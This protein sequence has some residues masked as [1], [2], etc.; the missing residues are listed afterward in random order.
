LDNETVVIATVDGRIRHI[1]MGYAVIEDEGTML[2]IETGDS[3]PRSQLGEFVERVSTDH[4][5]KDW[6]AKLELIRRNILSPEYDTRV[7]AMTKA[8]EELEAHSDE[9]NRVSIKKDKLQEGDIFRTFLKIGHQNRS[10][11]VDHIK[12]SKDGKLV[13]MKCNDEKV[14]LCEIDGISYRQIAEFDAKTTV[15]GA[16]GILRD[17]GGVV[18]CSGKNAHIYLRYGEQYKDVQMIKMP[19]VINSFKAGNNDKNLIFGCEDGSAYMY[20][21]KLGMP[22][23]ASK[24]GKLIWSWNN[25]IYVRQG[26]FKHD[27]PVA[28]VA[29][30]KDATTV[31]VAGGNSSKVYRYASGNWEIRESL[32]ILYTDRNIRGIEYSP[33]E[34]K[35]VVADSSNETVIYHERE[36]SYDAEKVFQGTE[37]WPPIVR[38]YNDGKTLLVLRK[39]RT[40]EIVEYIDGQYVVT[41][42]V[43]DA[44]GFTQARVMPD[45]SGIILCGDDGRL[46]SYAEGLVAVASDRHGYSLETG[47][48]VQLNMFPEYV[49]RLDLEVQG[50]SVSEQIGLAKYA[51]QQA[52]SNSEKAKK[53]K[54]LGGVIK[55]NDDKVET[56]DCDKSVLGQYDVIKSTVSID[57][58]GNENSAMQSDISKD[59][60]TMVVGG[61]LGKVNVYN[62]IEGKFNFAHEIA[63]DGS[64]SCLQISNDKKY[65]IIG[66]GKNVELHM[67][68][69]NTGVYSQEVAQTL[70]FDEEVHDVQMSPNGRDILVAKKRSL[71]LYRYNVH[72]RNFRRLSKKVHQNVNKRGDIRSLVFREDGKGFAMG[73]YDGH[74]RLFAYNAESGLYSLY[75][76]ICEGETRPTTVAYSPDYENIYVGHGGRL[77]VHSKSGLTDETETISGYM[78][79]PHPIAE[80]DEGGV[81]DIDVS[82]NGEFVLI[83]T[84]NDGART[85]RYDSVSETYTEMQVCPADSTT[86]IAKFLPDGTG[87]YHAGAAN[88]I[89]VYKEGLL[90]IDDNEYGYDLL[91][92]ERIRLETVSSQV[93]LVDVGTAGL[94]WEEKVQALKE[95][96]A[97]AESEREKEI[98]M[99]ALDKILQ[100]NKDKIN[101]EFVQTAQMNP[102]SVG[103]GLTMKLVQDSA[104]N[105]EYIKISQNGRIAVAYENSH[106]VV[107]YRIVNN[108]LHE[109]QRINRLRVG[110]KK[111]RKYIDISPD[112]STFV[113]GDTTAVIYKYNGSEFSLNTEIQTGC[114]VSSVKFTNDGKS[115]VVAPNE[116]GATLIYDMHD[117]GKFYEHHSVYGSADT[118]YADVTNDG[119]YLITGAA[120]GMATLYVY[121]VM[122]YKDTGMTI[123]SDN[124][125][126]ITQ[127]HFLGSQ[128]R[129]LVVT[130]D[131]ESYIYVL[132]GN[133]YKK[134][135]NVGIV[136][137]AKVSNDG[138]RFVVAHDKEAR[139]YEFDGNEYQC[140]DKITVTAPLQEVE[141]SG[142]NGVYLFKE[143]HQL[144][145]YRNTSLM[146][147]EDGSVSDLE[148]GKILHESEIPQTVNK[149]D[150]ESLNLEWYTKLAK[151]LTKYEQ[152]D[153]DAKKDQLL[154]QIKEIIEAHTGDLDEVEI[155]KEHLAPMTLARAL[156][157][158][159]TLEYGP[160]VYGM[161]I[162][163]DG[164]R[165]IIVSAD[166]MIHIYNMAEGEFQPLQ[167]LP[168]VVSGEAV[169]FSLD[170]NII[171]I[172]TE[173]GV[174]LY[175]FDG[176][177][178]V[179]DEGDM[180]PHGP[181][182]G[183]VHACMFSKDAKRL[184]VRYA[185]LLLF[186]YKLE[187]GKYMKDQEIELSEGVQK[188]DISSD[189]NMLAIG[190]TDGTVSVFTL[191]NDKYVETDHKLKQGDNADNVVILEKMGGLAVMTPEE[192]SYVYQFDGTRYRRSFNLGMI[193]SLVRNDEGSRLT[194][195]DRT[196]VRLYE[197]SQDGIKLVQEVGFKNTVDEVAFA[198]DGGIYVWTE[199][200][201]CHQYSEDKIVIINENEARNIKT[202][203]VINM[204]DIP[205]KVACVDLKYAG[206][207]WR[208]R[209]SRAI[210]DYNSAENDDDINAAR[211]VVGS[212]L[213]RYETNMPTE[214]TKTVQ[215]VD[216]QIVRGLVQQQ[217]L[218]GQDKARYACMSAD[219]K[220]MARMHTLT[221]EYASGK[222]TQ[223]LIYIDKFNEET[224][225]YQYSHTLNVNRNSVEEGYPIR[226]SSDPQ[227]R[228]LLAGNTSG[229]I[230]FERDAG[231]RYEFEFRFQFNESFGDVRAVDF[232]H[233]ASEILISNENE[234]YVYDV[235]LKQSNAKKIKRRTTL[236]DGGTARFSPDGTCVLAGKDKLKVYK[237]DQ[238]GA[239]PEEGQKVSEGNITAAAWLG[240]DRI[241]AV[242][243]AGIEAADLVIYR[244][245]EA[246]EYEEDIILEDYN[247][248]KGKSITT[249]SDGKNFIIINEHNTTEKWSE[250]AEGKFVCYGELGGAQNDEDANTAEYSADGRGIAVAYNNGETVTFVNRTMIVDNE[251]QVTDIDT[252]EKIHRKDLPDSVEIAD[253]GRKPL[254]W[255]QR[256]N[257][258]LLQLQASEDDLNGKRVARYIGGILRERENEIDT[259]MQKADA[260][261]DL[262]VGRC[263]I[264]K[265]MP[266]LGH[267]VS[268]MVW[269]NDGRRVLMQCPDNQLRLYNVIGDRFVYVQQFMYALSTEGVRFSQDG[270]KIFLAGLNFQVFEYN[271]QEQKY[272]EAQLF[273]SPTEINMIKISP[274]GSRIYIAGNDGMIYIYEFNGNEYAQKAPIQ[275]RTGKLLRSIDVSADGQRIVVTPSEEKP[276]IYEFDG[277]TYSFS[278]HVEVKENMLDAEFLSDGETIVVHNFDDFELSVV[279]YRNGTYSEFEELGKVENFTLSNDR[280]TVIGVSAEGKVVMYYF[281]GISIE[282]EYAMNAEVGNKRACMGGDRRIFVHADNNTVRQ[283]MPGNFIVVDGD[284]ARDLSTGDAF[285][286]SSLPERVEVF[287]VGE[288]KGFWM[289]DMAR[290]Q[291]AYRKAENDE[292]RHQA[293]Q[294]IHRLLRINRQDL[295]LRETQ[296]DM[297]QALDVIYSDILVDSIEE[298]GAIKDI[299]VSADKQYVACLREIRQGRAGSLGAEEYI[300][301][302]LYVYKYDKLQDKYVFLDSSVI[303]M[304]DG[305]RSSAFCVRFSKDKES[306]RLIIGGDGEAFAFRKNSDGQY[307]REQHIDRTKVQGG[308]YKSID[309]SPDGSTAIL[310]SDHG[311]AYILKYDKN[312][313]AGE[314]YQVSPP[315]SASRVTYSEDG[316]SLLLGTYEMR[317]VEMLNDGHFVDNQNSFTES[318]SIDGDQGWLANGDVIAG[319]D[320]GILRLFRKDSSG[321]YAGVQDITHG[322]SIVKIKVSCSRDQILTI[323]D[324]GVCRL[325][326]MDKS[327]RLEMLREFK[328]FGVRIATVDFM[329]DGSGFL[330]GYEDKR[331]EVF[332]NEAI[333]VDNEESSTCLR[334]GEP[335]ERAALPARVSV[336]AVEEGR[337]SEGRDDR[338]DEAR[339]IQAAKRKISGSVSEDEKNAGMNALEGVIKRNAENMETSIIET[340]QLLANDIA[341][342]MVQ[343]KPLMSYCV[344][345]TL[346]AS[347]NGKYLAVVKYVSDEKSNVLI[348]RYDD[349]KMKYEQ[350]QE[351]VGINTYILS[352]EF[353]PDEYGSRLVIGGEGAAYE[354]TLDE[355]GEYRLEAEIGVG[356]DGEPGWGDATCYKIS[357]SS[358]GKYALFGLT[359]DQAIIYQFNA[360]KKGAER[361]E[362]I[363]S[364]TC[365]GLTASFTRDGSSIILA[366]K[367]D[368]GV[369]MHPVGSDINSVKEG[370]RIAG[371]HGDKTAIRKAELSGNGNVMVVTKETK[372][373]VCICEKAGENN[374]EMVQT[375]DHDNHVL[376]FDINKRGNRI[377]TGDTKG[378]ITLWE[379]DR[380]GKYI[381]IR[382]SKFDREIASVKFLEDGEGIVAAG[383]HDMNIRIFRY[384]NIMMTGN[385]R[386]A[387]LKDGS[388]IPLEN[389]PEK[390]HL[391]DL[392]YMSLSWNE[393]LERQIALIGRASSFRETKEAGARIRRILNE[394][395]GEIDGEETPLEDA[396]ELSL[397]RAYAETGVIEIGQRVT[398]AKVSPQGDSVMHIDSSR[399]VSDPPMISHIEGQTLREDK[400]L[401]GVG[402]NENTAY[403]NSGKVIARYEKGDVVV[404]RFDGKEFIK[405]QV[406]EKL[407]LDAHLIFSND[408]SL[409]LAATFKSKVRVFKHEEG[410][411]IEIDEIRME[412]SEK[413]VRSAAI[414]NDHKRLLVNVKEAEGEESYFQVYDFNEKEREFKLTASMKIDGI[415][416]RL[417]GYILG[418]G[419]QF[420]IEYKK[421]HFGIFHIM[422]GEL[423]KVQEIGSTGNISISDDGQ[424]VIAGKY[425]KAVLYS[426]NGKGMVRIKDIEMP[427]NICDCVFVGSDKFIIATRDGLMHV[428]TKKNYII[429]DHDTVWDVESSE[430]VARDGF[431]TQVELLEIE[432]REE[433][434]S[435]KFGESMFALAKPIEE[436]NINERMRAAR[437]VDDVINNQL[438][439]VG[440]IEKMKNEVAPGDLVR[441]YHLEKKQP[442]GYTVSDVCYSPDGRKIA[443]SMNESG[444]LGGVEIYEYDDESRS[445]KYS[446]ELEGISTSVFCSS[447]SNDG[448]G[449]RIVVG[450]F[451][452]VWVYKLNENGVYVEEELIH[453]TGTAIKAVEFSQNNKE[454]MFCFASG[455]VDVFGYSPEK[456]KGMRYEKIDRNVVTSYA[457]AKYIER[458]NRYLALSDMSREVHFRDRNEDGSYTQVAFGEDVDDVLFKWDSTIVHGDWISVGNNGEHI[459]IGLR[460]VN[461]SY[462]EVR[463]FDRTE[464]G[465]Y[466]EA[467]VIEHD[468]GVTCGSF[469]IDGNRLVF[470]DSKGNIFLYQKESANQYN[471]VASYK[472][473]R[474]V[475]SVRFSPDESSITAGALREQGGGGL[476]GVFNYRNFYIRDDEVAVKLDT[477]ADVQIS[478]LPDVMESVDVDAEKLGG[479]GDKSDSSWKRDVTVALLELPSA[480]EKS[481][482]DALIKIIRKH[483]DANEDDMIVQGEEAGVL[484]EFAATLGKGMFKS[485]R[486]TRG[487]GLDIVLDDIKIMQV[488]NDG[489]TIMLSDNKSKVVVH[490][491]DH[492]TNSYK[493]FQVIE[494]EFS[495]HLEYA[496]EA[497]DLTA[498][499]PDGKTIIIVRDSDD[500]IL[501]QM[502]EQTNTFVVRD[503]LDTAPE[504]CLGF[505]FSEDGNMLAIGGQESFCV[506]EKNPATQQFELVDEQ[507]DHTGVERM[508]FSKNKNALVTQGCSL[509]NTRSLTPMME[510]QYMLQGQQIQTSIPFREDIMTSLIRSGTQIF[511]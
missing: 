424:T 497:Y 511:R 310:A 153:S 501:Y 486:L 88:N 204:D 413:W 370:I 328:E 445:Y 118:Q 421:G 318:V 3:L 7:H 106:T 278:Q 167:N 195:R 349:E 51:F 254:S 107:V 197:V 390:A 375:L 179:K 69:E 470:G 442:L 481:K 478:K 87:F 149:Y 285:S 142:N 248:A 2:N 282:P 422:D 235:D 399:N 415:P 8:K 129:I 214:M 30:T 207:P 263:H 173:L 78:P 315:F 332:S 352:A 355:K 458:D 430:A 79:I 231:G 402:L 476:F 414:S 115:V 97:S 509:S 491:Y 141:L 202:G 261:A 464:T 37:N 58:V 448:E 269:S 380:T 228:W 92:G 493:E 409:L 224:G 196:A 114:A 450:G 490:K 431:Q 230:L 286:L 459:M 385:Q 122:G 135:V 154:V 18:V 160:R 39:G 218:I 35:L 302:W 469:S 63:V 392:D 145:Y 457:D 38:Y 433:D 293:R 184:F 462:G 508:W 57:V 73:S 345:N 157:L 243:D 180:F 337:E 237:R 185:G 28:S 416:T 112:G 156:I 427:E 144:L 379:K 257:Q 113:V 456:K 266:D 203:D 123:E 291:E 321:K 139:V 17:G 381:S 364:I 281:D 134:M 93:R 110:Y 126:P 391:L 438:K 271:E 84:S 211:R 299:A 289:E 372:G 50:R 461:D 25:D 505:A 247:G 83:A 253:I 172:G 314:R 342:A 496:M 216:T 177:E 405:D 11:N 382:I 265:K 341:R 443:V 161:K 198:P 312:G 85:Y 309:F 194:V 232:N 150:I 373:L 131:Q 99:R 14:R 111:N 483:A 71:F 477:G 223:S 20:A 333:I 425:E 120:T 76:E 437:V 298:E 169:S 192:N 316:S 387:V 102:L 362:K 280:H 70:E 441:A 479:R 270:R 453:D 170:G 249:S 240:S 412:G 295:N 335:V 48:Y 193:N 264:P 268:A 452:K 400:L 136:D 158:K 117:D 449:E 256:L 221:A 500:P 308:K 455:G 54:E 27:N 210:S 440:P 359:G 119:K 272:K 98:M 56:V 277:T 16:F 446:Q 386:A 217:I 360:D 186:V 165:V 55:R 343:E 451:G 220:T 226:F 23:P 432:A 408:D 26:V 340:H 504:Y 72:T 444:P 152:A 475:H 502:D 406:L 229:A 236:K 273:T 146:S 89:Y 251:S 388:E 283:Y 68:D 338:T 104:G 238:D 361:Y 323:T 128:E 494:E 284:T 201:N 45:G 303:K 34:N 9:I 322:A 507:P 31:I 29:M 487:D 348:Y 329:P 259:E 109:I 276:E 401:S 351:I 474:H 209:L 49:D 143:N 356:T 420:L 182:P 188:A 258:G 61:L 378:I 393:R 133:Q 36:G 246:E 116:F 66:T 267:K 304:G 506:Y 60:M 241:V 222:R 86:N 357:F 168:G 46:I 350:V 212:I 163:S 206:T 394:H 439:E 74:I 510:K 482:R 288:E 377:V 366:D 465:E 178:Y 52:D 233:D 82:D 334:T 417:E 187:N 40:A 287:D 368:N 305:L 499:S 80:F 426:Y 374:Y 108:V 164:K 199:A 1:S 162:S 100:D 327:G 140:K 64:V 245:T 423:I 166:N 488:S 495:N 81:A 239:Y 326:G 410:K 419:E 127:V 147:M 274:D 279:S 468:N 371:W 369:W 75:Q 428:Y 159:K 317:M 21:L 460:D 347:V 485:E 411:Y 320:N 24:L 319:L 365:S 155:E 171:A 13:M 225:K 176:K 191:Q 398:K 67:L 262:T 480:T 42:V 403:S 189:G 138:K 95:K 436:V 6:R 15:K 125:K 472:F 151:L 250:D 5:G 296:S 91:S 12:Y 300:T 105:K 297:L 275:T 4:S 396:G 252:G 397:V 290:A 148:T 324:T 367:E 77:L 130:P 339:I 313:A 325:F 306:E 418:E 473:G 395:D 94:T 215:L 407:G 10:Y 103:E 466:V 353:S 489:E 121:N 205:E 492:A 62:Y 96:I 181:I 354:Y 376:S 307:V 175:I 346:A 41:N 200:G 22:K 301:S 447:F 19:G 484:P 219:G 213:K 467:A 137:M 53:A 190:C 429:L 330:L 363:G 59:G 311:H 242:R 174:G 47:N 434:V 44:N 336:V 227:G 260:I 404:Y 503:V 463:I 208:V 498:L 43:H 124:G 331:I 454:V 255:R 132:D 65:L 32:G 183:I 383:A 344:K 471:P 384:K 101:R 389:M 244:I 90:I 292:S 435:E 294:G 234:T 358:N 33:D